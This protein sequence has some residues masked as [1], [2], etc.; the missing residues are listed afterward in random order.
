MINSVTFKNYRCFG[1]FTLNELSKVNI[2]VGM[3]NSGKSTILEG[4]YFLQSGNWNI[5]ANVLGRRGWIRHAV[6]PSNP[7][8]WSQYFNFKD[9]L[10]NA[11]SIKRG[12]EY[13]SIEARNSQDFSKVEMK[14]VNPNAKLDS[15]LSPTD[16]VL[17]NFLGQQGASMI[18][19]TGMRAEFSNQKG[20]F[21]T[22]LIP[23]FE[24]VEVRAETLNHLPNVFSDQRL[25]PKTHFIF[26]ESNDMS[27]A[28]LGWSQ[29]AF[30]SD[31]VS[32]I[33]DILKLTK[34]DIEGIQQLQLSQTMPPSFY[35]KLKDVVSP[36][37]LGSL[38][39]GVRRILYLLLAFPFAKGGIVF[40]D[41]IETGIHFSLMGKL[42]EMVL[43]FANKYEVQVFATTHSLDCIKGVSEIFNENL[44]SDISVHRIDKNNQKSINYSQKEIFEAVNLDEEIRGH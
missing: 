1:D 10:F 3:N 2:L 12:E 44:K 5:L 19:Q 9:S 15:Q 37:P 8:Q 6:T 31:V 39:D 27:S 41:E 34:N 4:L 40:I 25:I 7:N 28:L 11:S 43:E 24:G 21:I 30:Q 26:P 32:K 36:C 16:S 29:I 42:W 13:F 38:G 20:S 14:F 33:I 23:L 17:Y 18:G 22:P 35:L